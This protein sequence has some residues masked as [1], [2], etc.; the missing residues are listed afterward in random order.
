[1]R[2]CMKGKQYKAWLN[3]LV[4]S[5]PVYL[6]KSGSLL[7]MRQRVKHRPLQSYWR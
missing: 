2:K 6:Q 7:P 3:L 4:T 5:G 1:M